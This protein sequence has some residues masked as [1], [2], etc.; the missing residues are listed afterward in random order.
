MDSKNCK[1]HNG[2]RSIGKMPRGKEKT[3]GREFL[4]IRVLRGNGERAW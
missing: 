4:V 3:V 2:K 1:K